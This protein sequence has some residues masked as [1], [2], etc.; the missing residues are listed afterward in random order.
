MGF[1]A[2]SLHLFTNRCRAKQN[3][4][5]DKRTYPTSFSYLQIVTFQVVKKSEATSRECQRK[6]SNLF[7]ARKNARILRLRIALIINHLCVFG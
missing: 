2:A 7:L 6:S 5:V 3:K 1:Y 4:N